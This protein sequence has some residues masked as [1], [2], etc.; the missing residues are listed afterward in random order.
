MLLTDHYYCD[1]NSISTSPEKSRYEGYG[2]CC[3]PNS[4]SVNC[5]DGLS[6]IQCTSGPAAEQGV[7]LYKTFWTGMTPEIC[8]T[9]TYDLKA[10]PDKNVLQASKIVIQ[11]R[12]SAEYEACHWIISVE[13]YTYRDDTNAY[14]ELR[15]ETIDNADVYLYT[16]TGRNNATTYIENNSTAQ[17][18]APFRA[19]ISSKLIVVASTS[20]NSINA[21]NVAFTY[22]LF[23]QVEY[24]WFFKP[25][26]G[27][28]KAA[29]YFATAG[30]LLTPLIILVTVV[31]FCCYCKCCRNCCCCCDEESSESEVSPVRP[32]M[33]RVDVSSD[34]MADKS[35]KSMNITQSNVEL[36]EK[37]V[38][39]VVGDSESDLRMRNISEFSGD[40]ND[41][42]SDNNTAAVGAIGLGMVSRM[43]LTSSLNKSRDKNIKQAHGISYEDDIVNSDYASGRNNINAL[44]AGRP[45]CKFAI[46]L[47]HVFAP[48]L[49]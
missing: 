43:D 11:E 26:V 47:L 41:I 1:N 18:G 31:L 20:A 39:P 5:Q 36:R 8:G 38:T 22:Q 14:I 17:L 6:G 40:A 48:I 23:N 29:W 45:N 30:V 7:P 32:K 21:G 15:F 25:F 35:N 16:G 9:T 28:V 46:Q 37:S 27:E 44:N 13:D 42:A 2:Y 12:V 33:N 24:S 10:T 4:K 49:I 19:P 3:P 34:K